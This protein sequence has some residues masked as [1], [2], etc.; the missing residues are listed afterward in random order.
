MSYTSI[1]KFT[2]FLLP[3]PIFMGLSFNIYK[4]SGYG[5]ANVLPISFF[6]IFFISIVFVKR[7]FKI[8]LLDKLII[9]NLFFM[10]LG[11]SYILLTS[12]DIVTFDWL[13]LYSVPM[14]FGYFYGRSIANY[15][16]I[17]TFL[18]IIFYAVGLISFLHV[19]WS[20]GN[21][22]LIYTIINRGSDDVLGIFSIYQKLVSYPLI[23]GIV[24]FLLIFSENVIKNKI[25]KSFLIIFIFLDLIVVAARE[26]FAML[27]FM[28]FLYFIKNFSFSNMFKI[29]MI[30]LS[31]II[32]LMII[33]IFYDLENLYIFK[34]FFVFFNPEDTT[35][36]TGGRL[37]N[38][39]NFYYYI[40]TLNPLFG[41][42]FGYTEI[43]G[44]AHNQWLDMLTKGGVIYW[45]FIL[46]IF[47]YSIYKTQYFI[48]LNTNYL[49]I[50]IVL[51]ALMLINFNINTALRTP[52]TS[53]FIWLLIGF[54]SIKFKRNNKYMKQLLQDLKKGEILLEEIPLPNCGK[55]EV[56]NKNRKKS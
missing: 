20:I 42:G 1:S 8:N 31:F 35:Q 26:P 45:I 55:N 34:K 37:H 6:V 36:A 24:L 54:N 12:R 4:G 27:A 16:D 28:F 40:T 30:I 48:N 14:I 2:L 21:Y 18:K 43:R 32:M 33:N 47:L 13:L 9:L 22:G 10:I 39:I 17:N 56:S 38:F 51:I 29:F 53:I 25:L 19:S 50:S 41:E 11:Y 44:S 49:L 15:I 23:L 3:L 5:A 46:N 7:Y 52:Y